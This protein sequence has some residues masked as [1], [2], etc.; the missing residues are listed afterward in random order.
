MER[1]RHDHSARHRQ[2]GFSQRQRLGLMIA[3][4]AIACG[5]VVLI[6]HEMS[7]GGGFRAARAIG[8]LAAIGLVLL[9][10]AWRGG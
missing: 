6:L 2:G 7:G 4:L 3:A 9:G 1:A 5:L 10:L 8:L